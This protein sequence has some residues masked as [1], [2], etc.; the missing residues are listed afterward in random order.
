MWVSI[1]IVV[2]SWVPMRGYKASPLG[3]RATIRPGSGGLASA[4]GLILPALS[5]A[6]HPQVFRMLTV[7]HAPT[8]VFAVL[9]GLFRSVTTNIVH[10]YW[11]LSK[12]KQSVTT[13]IVIFIDC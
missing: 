2:I 4:A 8:I 12:D 9:Q 3:C 10:P 1:S 11:A 7:I 6:H 5:G 13:L